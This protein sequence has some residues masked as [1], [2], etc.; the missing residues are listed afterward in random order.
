MNKRDERISQKSIWNVSTPSDVALTLPFYGIESGHFFAEKEYYVARDFHDS[1][2]LLFCINGSGIVTSESSEFELMPGQGILLDCHKPHSYYSAHASSWDFLWL[3]FNGKMAETY[4]SLVNPEGVRLLSFD[5]NDEF[6]TLFVSLSENL[7]DKDITGSLLHSSQIE[8]LLIYAASSRFSQKTP[9]GAIEG[10]IKKA[11][12]LMME[13]YASPI[14]L[15]DLCNDLHISKYHFVR[16]FRRIM[17]IPPYSFLIN[18]RITQAK[19]LLVTSSLSIEEISEK[20]GF[21]DCAGFISC[22]KSH[23]GETP[24][25][26]R[27]HHFEVI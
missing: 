2:L 12:E 18:Y 13:N 22:F 25:H 7:S 24:L 20:T 17:G 27:R 23:V 26:Y 3:H 19:R 11:T 6:L 14:S 16:S 8:G 21:K 10:T 15:D 9:T 1:F 5:K 4:Y